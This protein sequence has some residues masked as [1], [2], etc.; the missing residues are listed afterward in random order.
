[1]AASSMNAT[2]YETS[3]AELLT[4]PVPSLDQFLRERLDGPYDFLHFKQPII[5]IQNSRV[6]GYE[7]TTA[8]LSKGSLS[9]HRP[10]LL[11]EKMVHS[12]LR[13]E[14][15]WRMV[16]EV[17]SNVVNRDSEGGFY[18]FVNVSAMASIL[19]IDRRSFRHPS[20]VVLECGVPAILDDRDLEDV[21]V[22]IETLRDQGFKIALDLNQ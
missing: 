4:L 15:D 12:R 14:F 20:R 19:K 18:W 16:R 2:L 5:D 3:E 17:A 10:N 8:L 9:I 7:V 6:L 22:Q 21:R 1:M 13:D 11:L